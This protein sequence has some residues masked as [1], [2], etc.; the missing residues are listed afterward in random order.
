M[1][2][3]RA[4]GIENEYEC[5]IQ[6]ARKLQPRHDHMKHNLQPR[7]DHM[8]HNLMLWHHNNLLNLGLI[9]RNPSYI[10]WTFQECMKMIEWHESSIEGMSLCQVLV[11][12]HTKSKFA[13]SS[14]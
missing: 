3:L 6:S 7:H 5:R 12:R 9:V 4:Y 10:F 13:S 1:H 11:C 8:K 2:E 14:N